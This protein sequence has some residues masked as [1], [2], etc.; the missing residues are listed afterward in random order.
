MEFVN[1]VIHSFCWQNG[2]IHETTILYMPEQNGIAESA[3][4]VCFEM[5]RCMLHS[6]GMDLQYWGEA[7]MYTV[8]I[9][10]LSPISAIEDN[11][12]LYFWSRQKLDISHLC[13]FRLI[14]YAN[15]PKNIQSGKLE[16][17]TVKCRLL[18]WWRDETK[19]YR[20]EDI[21]MCSLITSHDVQF[22][23]DE[24]PT[25]LTIIKGDPPPVQHK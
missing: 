12:P 16:V 10:N 8:H 15:I 7:F 18:G 14:V 5:V 24:T 22:V 6:A 17:T 1:N 4:C 25:E 19:G 13:V 2:I 11:V 3:I 9:R 23:E 20:L 21:Q